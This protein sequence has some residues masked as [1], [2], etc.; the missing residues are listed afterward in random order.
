MHTRQIC[1]A[2]LADTNQGRV[3]LDA[4]NLAKAKA[5]GH[6]HL[7]ACGAA[8]YE[9]AWHGSQLITQNR[10]QV[11]EASPN[12]PQGKQLVD[13]AFHAVV[14]R[15]AV[16]VDQHGTGCV[17]MLQRHGGEGVSDDGSRLGL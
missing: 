1:Q 12:M 15:G 17:V 2:Q 14:I 4:V 13:L 8:R 5:S 7:R 16:Q 6:D 9:Y 10:A 3:D 11:D